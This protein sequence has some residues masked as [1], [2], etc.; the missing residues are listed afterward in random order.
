M[1]DG[2]TSAF[3][4]PEDFGGSVCLEVSVAQ[5]LYSTDSFDA[6][7]FVG[8][9]MD[10]LNEKINKDDSKTKDEKMEK[11]LQQDLSAHHVRVLINEAK[12]PNGQVDIKHPKWTHL[13]LEKI[14]DDAF[15][16]NQINWAM[17][18]EN[19]EHVTRDHSEILRG[20]FDDITKRFEKT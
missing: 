7:K 4:I 11:F 17:N 5:Y 6:M 9:K 12:L 19:G 20:T 14:L 10:S 15:V 16:Q 1:A 18:Q 13:D 3:Y 8:V 2:Y